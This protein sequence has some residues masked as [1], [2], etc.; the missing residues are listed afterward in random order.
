[1]NINTHPTAV[2]NKIRILKGTKFKS[3]PNI[4]NYNLTEIKSIAKISSNFAEWFQ[5][6]SSNSNYEDNFILQKNEIKS[7]FAIELT[8]Q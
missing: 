7:K 4:M 8:S 2:W 1:M 6:N 3:I 5:L